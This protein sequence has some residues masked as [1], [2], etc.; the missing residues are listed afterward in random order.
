MGP[1]TAKNIIDV[2]GRPRGRVVLEN[3]SSTAPGSR[4]FL[5]AGG[6]ALMEAVLDRAGLL[7]MP[8]IW[9]L[10]FSTA[11]RNSSQ[12]TPIVVR[13]VTQ[14]SIRIKLKPGD[15][16]T[17][18]ECFLMV[19]RDKGDPQTIRKLLL[20]AASDL[21][22]A[23]ARSRTPAP[24]TLPQPQPGQLVRSS[25]PLVLA[26]A[27]VTQITSACQV[28]CDHDP[29]P[30][31]DDSALE[32]DAQIPELRISQ[33]P[34]PALPAVTVATGQ[35]DPLPVTLPN[36]D[37]ILA[38][39]DLIQ[40]LQSVRTSREDLLRQRSELDA[41]IA[42][43]NAEEAELLGKFSSNQLQDA[44]AAL[45]AVERSRAGMNPTPASVKLLASTA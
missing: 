21:M 15:N 9:R 33:P 22:M 8:G 13:E 25:P 34:Q 28:D 11:L 4:G 39:A 29:E 26:P 14:S 1:M 6:E 37:A 5:A 19:D 35:A 42:M 7:E 40:N 23:N 12:T 24:A 30:E 20:E 38:A 32:F 27:N 10:R 18:S 31:P 16:S 41:L 2:H 45:Q 43:S 17:A 3:H 36:V 44:I